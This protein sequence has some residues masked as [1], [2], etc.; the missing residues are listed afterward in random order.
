MLATIKNYDLVCYQLRNNYYSQLDN[1]LKNDID[2]LSKD[3]IDL[4][5]SRKKVQKQSLDV[6][7]QVF[8]LRIKAIKWLATEPDFDYLETLSEVSN[9]IETIK[10]NKQLEVLNENIQFAL[11]CNQRVFESLFNEDDHQSD[12]T[13]FSFSQLQEITYQQFIA[14]LAF[15][16]PDAHTAQKWVDWINASLHI[17]Y[18]MLCADIIIDEKI[19]VSD[20][21]IN[22]LSFLVADAAQDY[23]ALATDLGLLKPLKERQTFA[24]FTF[25]DSFINEQKVL[26]DI[27][28]D[29]FATK[30]LTLS[31]Q[32]A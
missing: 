2:R 22:E 24:Q 28:L 8:N 1:P 9:Q 31:K 16:I 26:A 17:E 13:N 30:H 14:T 23:F 19:K 3:I 27:G 18:V 7:S 20:K 12:N 6:L 25:D 11:R 10:V 32:Y 21:T 5:T 15:T 29:D 4:L